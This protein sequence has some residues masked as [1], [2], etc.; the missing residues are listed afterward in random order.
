MAKQSRHEAYPAVQEKAPA[1]SEYAGEESAVASRDARVDP[2]PKSTAPHASDPPRESPDTTKPSPFTRRG[3]MALQRHDFEGAARP[4]SAGDRPVPRRA[5]TA[6][7]VGPLPEGLRAGNGQEAAGA[8]DRPGKGVR[9][10]GRAQ[11]RGPR[12]RLRPPPPR[13]GR[14]PGQRSRALHH[15]GRP[16]VSGANA[17]SLRTPEALHRTE[18]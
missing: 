11:C 2:R 3:V 8:S 6:R 14:L 17:R 7:A 15:G 5:R 18:S 13:P 4:V 16:G 9:G 10:H 1:A 12:D